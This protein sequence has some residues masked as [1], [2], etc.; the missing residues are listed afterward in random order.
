[1]VPL[2]ADELDEDLPEVAPDET[3]ALVD[4]PEEAEDEAAVEREKKNDDPAEA[5]AGIVTGGR[6]A[7]ART[8][9]IKRSRRFVLFSPNFP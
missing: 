8:S 1:M 7:R 9:D 6:F 3:D 4:W 5:E 2:E